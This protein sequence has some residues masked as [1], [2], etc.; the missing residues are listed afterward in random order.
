MEI[1]IVKTEA[2]TIMMKVIDPIGMIDVLKAII[3]DLATDEFEKTKKSLYTKEDLLKKIDGVLELHR[4]KDDGND[5]KYADLQELHKAADTCNEVDCHNCAFDNIVESYNLFGHQSIPLLKE[6]RNR[7]ND[8]PSG[9]FK[10]VRMASDILIQTIK[11]A[12]FA[13]TGPDTVN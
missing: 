2:G 10:G 8:L 6:V 9:G 12:I 1:S 7:I 5:V 11:E 3:K 4:V 13:Q